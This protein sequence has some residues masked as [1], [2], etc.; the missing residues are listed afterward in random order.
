MSS[1]FLCGFFEHFFLL[2][3]F[4]LQ[5]PILDKDDLKTFGNDVVHVNEIFII[6]H[7]RH[8]YVTGTGEHV[9]SHGERVLSRGETP[10]HEISGVGLVSKELY[11]ES[12]I[13][14]LIKELL[15][16][17]GFEHVFQVE[18]EGV[19]H[20]ECHSR[21]ILRDTEEVSAALFKLSDK[22]PISAVVLFNSLVQ[23]LH[24]R[25]DDGSGKVAHAKTVVGECC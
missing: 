11:G 17:F 20:W 22:V 2:R 13:F 15:D 8:S 12:V 25:T 18:L 16:H 23:S 14:A 24:L 4:C 5:K 10:V 3:F 7:Q 21:C 6:P 19:V 9:S 1:S